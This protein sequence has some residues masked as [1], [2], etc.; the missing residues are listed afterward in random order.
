MATAVAV[1]AVAAIAAAVQ[2]RSCFVQ[3]AHSQFAVVG[4]PRDAGR[5]LP[6][7]ALPQ[8]VPVSAA[9]FR[10]VQ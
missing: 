4:P 5:D 1:G 8:C 6:Y 2:V 7:A 10:A 9:Q 3:F